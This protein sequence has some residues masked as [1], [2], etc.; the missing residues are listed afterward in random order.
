MGDQLAFCLL[1]SESLINFFAVYYL[2]GDPLFPGGHSPII[3]S[4]FLLFIPSVVSSVC[5]SLTAMHLGCKEFV[6][7]M[8]ELLFHS[9]A[10]TKVCVYP[11]VI[12]CL[13]LCLGYL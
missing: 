7:W 11:W 6:Y 10:Y 8:R 9:P 4:V 1:T 3:T 13:L 2:G 5:L 12:N